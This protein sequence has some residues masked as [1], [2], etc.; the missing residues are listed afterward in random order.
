MSEATRAEF[1][2]DLYARLAQYANPDGS[3]DWSPPLFRVFAMR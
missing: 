3:L 2:A 1:Y